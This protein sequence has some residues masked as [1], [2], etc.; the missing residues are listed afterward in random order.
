MIDTRGNFVFEQEG[1]N[2]LK[3]MYLSDRHEVA[4]GYFRAKGYRLIDYKGDFLSARYYDEVDRFNDEGFAW[5]RKG[6]ESYFV[7]AQGARVF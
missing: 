7:D 6:R 5:V 3:Y 4:W 1:K 2:R